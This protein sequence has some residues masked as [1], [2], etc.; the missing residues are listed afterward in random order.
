MKM[1]MLGWHEETMAITTPRKMGIAET[2]QVEGKK[3]GRSDE[4]YVHTDGQSY[5]HDSCFNRVCDVES[6]GSDDTV[7]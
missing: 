6:E 1:E 3:S 7:L 4:E 5:F 2:C